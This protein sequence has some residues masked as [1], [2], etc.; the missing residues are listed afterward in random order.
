[1]TNEEAN[2]LYSGLSE[3]RW[4]K[5]FFKTV[6]G[7]LSRLEEMIIS[8]LDEFTRPCSE[9]PGS[10]KTYSCLSFTQPKRR[11]FTWKGEFVRARTQI[12]LYEKL[13]RRIF[14]EFPDRREEIS[15]SLNSNSR[16][17]PYVARCREDLYQGKTQEWICQH[18][19]LLVDGWYFDK[20]LDQSRKIKLLKQSLVTVGLRFNS[21]VCICWH[22]PRTK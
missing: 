6:W 7:G 10:G 1:M 8:D 15:V 16:T 9:M 3:L 20:N 4:A 12:E 17:R 19:D 22:T 2:R 14:Q 21:D 18:S 5:N 13:M 11:G